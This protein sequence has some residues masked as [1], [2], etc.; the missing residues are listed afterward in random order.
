VEPAVIA[1]LPQN[2]NGRRSGGG[3]SGCSSVGGAHRQDTEPNSDAGGFSAA[4][5]DSP[6]TVGIVT[7]SHSGTKGRPLSRPGRSGLAWGESM[8]PPLAP[9][10][11]RK[12]A[13][14]ERVLA[15]PV[16]CTNPSA[17]QGT[18]SLAWAV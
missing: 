11:R 7:Q 1:G 16:R 8:R 5:T 15:R 3:P 10:T 9:G 4:A 6:H 18:L 2:A 13:L 12:T 14:V 17:A